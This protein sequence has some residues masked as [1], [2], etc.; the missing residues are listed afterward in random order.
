M[1]FEEKIV[2]IFKS[3]F[4]SIIE[5]E[6]GWIWFLCFDYFVYLAY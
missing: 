3:F 2:T 1:L 5:M 6:Y 4:G